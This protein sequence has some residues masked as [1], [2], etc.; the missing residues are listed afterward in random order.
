MKHTANM[1]PMDLICCGHSVPDHLFSDAQRADMTGSPYRAQD[2]DGRWYSTTL[3][4]KDRKFRQS[5]WKPDTG[6]RADFVAG[7]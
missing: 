4:D 5:Y 1:T 7:L 6:H 3:N 2:A